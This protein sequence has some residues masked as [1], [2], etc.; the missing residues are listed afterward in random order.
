MAKVRKIK[1]KVSIVILSYNVEKLLVQCLNSLLADSASDNWQ[2]IVVD[3]NSQDNSVAAVRKFGNVTLIKSEENLGFSA[4]NNLAVGEIQG[5]YTLFLNPDT[6]V[7]KGAIAMVERYLSAHPQVG[8][9]TCRV[10]LPDGKLDNGCHRGFPT[11]WNAFCYFSG[12][13]KLFPRSRW[14]AGYTLGYKP[15]DEIHEIEALTGAFMMLPTSVGR[16][17]GWWD[18]DYFWNGE[19]LDFCY[20]IK[21]SGL[22]VMYLPGAKI[23]HYKG[24][25]GGYK[26]TSHGKNA[27]DKQTKL[28]AARSSTRAMKIFYDKHYRQVYPRW[29]TWMVIKGI[30]LLE[31]IRVWNVKFAK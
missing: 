16:Q 21:K 28:M 23:T 17:L 25:S 27:V 7:D 26:S 20:R 9:A 30:G 8:A 29:M 11:P 22:K 18:E 31:Q 5:Q 10:A 19:D 4:G 15:M 6:V 3:N 12:L 1:S 2:I 13:G 24:S 14:L